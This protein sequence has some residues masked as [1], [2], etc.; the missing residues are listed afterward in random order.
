MRDQFSERVGPTGDG[1]NSN[2]RRGRQRDAVT[3]NIVDIDG[4]G[5][6][7]LNDCDEGYI[8]G[9]PVSLK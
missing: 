8:P 3:S 2:T 9:E 7:R 5:C 4:R 6:E 1:S